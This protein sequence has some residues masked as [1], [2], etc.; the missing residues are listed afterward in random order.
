MA[1]IASVALGLISFLLPETPPKAKGKA[2][3]SSA[4][5]AD[6]FVLFKDKPYLIFFIAALLVCVSARFLLWM[7]NVF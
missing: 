2:Q 7:G 5:G 3:L 4:L 1:A 6:A